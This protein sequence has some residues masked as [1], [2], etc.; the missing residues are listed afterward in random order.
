[1]PMLHTLEV[2][3]VCLCWHCRKGIHLN[4]KAD[5]KIYTCCTYTYKKFV[6]VIIVVVVVYRKKIIRS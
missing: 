4:R 6:V 5:T 2:A 3:M 1:M